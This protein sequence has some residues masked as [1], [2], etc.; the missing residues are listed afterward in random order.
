M[1]VDR[2]RQLTWLDQ[3][4]ASQTGSQRS[5][6]NAHIARVKYRKKYGAA[7]DSSQHRQACRGPHVKQLELLN[8]RNSIETFSPWQLLDNNGWIDPFRGHSDNI[9]D[10][11]YALEI[12]DYGKLYIN[13]P[14]TAV[15][16]FGYSHRS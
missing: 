2:M 7:R 9:L 15:V 3:T 11:P 4:Q 13:V 12:L 6:I 5:T 14:P 1:L 8:Q 16:S 10:T